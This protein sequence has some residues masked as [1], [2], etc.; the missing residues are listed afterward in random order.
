MITLYRSKQIGRYIN[1]CPTRWNTKQ[2]IILQVHSTCFGCQPHPSSG[3]HT[4]VTTAS[5]TGHIFCAATSFQ[6]WKKVD[7]QK[8]WPVSQAALTVLCT[9]DDGCGWH[10]KHVEWTCKIIDCFVFHLVGHLLIQTSD[11][12]NHKHNIHIGRALSDKWLC[13]TLWAI[14]WAKYRLIQLN[15]YGL[16]CHC[17]FDQRLSIME[18]DVSPEGMEGWRSVWGFWRR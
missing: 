16:Q 4:I 17:R 11:A 7:A 15:Y 1:K 18:G 13:I 10:P 9:P 12:R 14:C 5:G 6:R 3:V 8:I 2:S